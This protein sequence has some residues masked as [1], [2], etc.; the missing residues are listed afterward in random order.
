MIT[1]SAS[2]SRESSSTSPAPYYLHVEYHKSGNITTCTTTIRA[3][4]CT[5]MGP[6]GPCS[7]CLGA[8]RLVLRKNI[9]QL[10]SEKNELKRY[11]PLSRVSKTRVANALKI[12]RMEKTTALKELEDIKSKIKE[13]NLEVSV[14]THE[15]LKNIISSCQ[16][17]EHSFI[18]KFWEEQQKAFSRKPEGMRWHPMMVKFAILLHS[19][20]PSAYRSLREIGVL[21]LPS[22]STLRDYTNYVHPRAGFQMEVFDEL[23]KMAG[24]FQDHQRWVCLLHDEIVIKSGLVYDHVSGELVGFIDQAQQ[25]EKSTKEDH[26]ATHALVFMVVGMSSDIKMSI[27]YFPTRTATAD[28]IFPL[29]WSA[30][31]LLECVSNLKVRF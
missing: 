2:F 6:N 30:I 29:L 14:K 16:F 15:Q 1:Y 9:R 19:Q 11:S 4:S 24:N 22:E 20:S 7:A 25:N 12:A 26:L 5:G 27:G 28:E 18:H 10:I 8:R 13:E 31:G 21:K 17:E 23:K 3:Q